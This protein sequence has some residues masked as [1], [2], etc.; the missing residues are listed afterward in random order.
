MKNK[1]GMV[2]TQAKEVPSIVNQGQKSDQVSSID[3]MKGEKREPVMVSQLT[4]KVINEKGEPLHSVQVK[5]WKEGSSKN[6]FFKGLTDK[7][8]QIGLP[9][10]KSRFKSFKISAEK[11]NFFPF[12]GE[13]DGID[14]SEVLI[15][16]YPLRTLTFSAKNQFGD[17][18]NDLLFQISPLNTEKEE[19]P[20]NKLKNHAEDKIVKLNFI[21]GQEVMIPQNWLKIR[22]RI[23]K[24][25]GFVF[26]SWEQGGV[27]KPIFDQPPEIE[28][29]PKNGSILF[30]VAQ[31][32]YAAYRFLNRD[33][34]FVSDRPLNLLQQNSLALMEADGAGF[35]WEKDIEKKMKGVQV[36]FFIPKKLLK[37]PFSKNIYYL[38]D[39]EKIKSFRIL[40]KPF[41]GT[42]SVDT[43]DLGDPRGKKGFFYK[44]FLGIKGPTG[45][46][47]PQKYTKELLKIARFG[48]G[49]Y[50]VKEKQ[51]Q[52]FNIPIKNLGQHI[53]LPEGVYT[54]GAYSLMAYL[55]IDQVK[56]KINISSNHTKKESGVFL[57]LKKDWDLSIVRFHFKFNK[58][59]SVSGVFKCRRL[60]KGL[61]VPTRSFQGKVMV[62]ILLPPGT[63]NTK[64]RFMFPSKKD[65]IKKIQFKLNGGE[66]VDLEI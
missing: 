53:Y 57:Y 27:R 51:K 39:E 65:Q 23:Q 63:Y 11:K 28:I 47:K 46:K 10:K 32:Y 49:T 43:I 56:S 50:R 36:D 14:R 6:S 45:K 34:F 17:Q 54:Y 48:L 30:Q 38:V 42:I 8:G 41:L 33:L 21:M 58:G 7:M 5:T 20:L 26:Y 62:S 44:K 12:F 2:L 61:S 37:K 16:L 29:L 22:V 4:V 59:K 35:R 31:C 19:I 9:L 25:K 60:Y 52:R 18:V 3:S 15:I 55:S 64:F 24:Q 1:R 40:Y 13:I 66:C